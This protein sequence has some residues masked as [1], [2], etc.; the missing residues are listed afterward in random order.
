MIKIFP[1]LK[2]DTWIILA[3]LGSPLN[4]GAAKTMPDREAKSRA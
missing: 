1:I 4:W 2:I 3:R